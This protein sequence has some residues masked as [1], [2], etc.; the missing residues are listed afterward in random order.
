MLHLA[1]HRALLAL[2][3]YEAHHLLQRHTGMEARHV[4][5]SNLVLNV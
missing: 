1:T 5:A 4:A 3:T 2:P